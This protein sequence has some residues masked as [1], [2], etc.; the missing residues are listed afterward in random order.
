MC[1]VRHCWNTS[2]LKRNGGGVWPTGPNLMYSVWVS[3]R[4]KKEGE[5][6]YRAESERAVYSSD[7]Q[8][9]ERDASNEKSHL[10]CLPS[11]HTAVPPPTNTL[12]TPEELLEVSPTSPPLNRET[13]KWEN[14]EFIW[15]LSPSLPLSISLFVVFPVRPLHMSMRQFSIPINQLFVSVY[16]CVPT[17]ASLTY[18]GCCSL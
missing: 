10:N 18:I 2:R 15:P 1:T 17:P 9:T 8:D 5:K 3:A 14:G 7:S 4:K 13:P 6:N 16:V 11:P 12:W